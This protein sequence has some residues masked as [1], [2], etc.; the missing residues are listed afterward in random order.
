VNRRGLLAALLAFTTVSCDNSATDPG[1]QGPE[2]STGSG[3]SVVEYDQQTSQT[4]TL[5]SLRTS[6]TSDRLA[7]SL[8]LSTLGAP[9]L[10]FAASTSSYTTYDQR[11]DFAAVAGAIAHNYGFE[12]FAGEFFSFPPNPWT[13]NGVTYRTTNNLIVGP[14]T[15]F[16]P[17][18]RIFCYN[19]WTPVGG[20]LSPAAAYTVFGA[21]LSVISSSSLNSY[22]IDVVITT[23]LGIYRFDDLNVPKTNTKL[24]QFFGFVAKG[25]GEYIT[26]FELSSTGF[27]IGP[28]LDNVTVGHLTPVTP[29]TGNA[30][31]TADAGGPYAAAEGSRI[32]VTGS[33]TDPDPDSALTYGWDFDGDDVTDAT[34]AVAQHTYSQDGEYKARLI[35]SDGTLADTAEATINIAN[36]LPVVNAGPDQSGIPVGTS[37][38]ITPSFTDP[39]TDAPWHYSIEWSDGAEA[40]GTLATGDVTDDDPD[41]GENGD[42]ALPNVTFTAP[43]AG[44]FTITVKVRD[45]DGESSDVM[46]VAA[47]KKTAQVTLGGL[48]QSYDGSPRSA[49]ATTDPTGLKVDLTYDGKS[50][51]PTNVGSYT[52]V[53]TID[54]PGYEGSATGTLEITK[55]SQTISFR[56]LGDKTYGDQPFAVSATASSGLAV[57]VSPSGDCSISG[58]TVTIGR[59]GSCTIT[60]SQEGNGNYNPAESVQ[61]TF[62]IAK[63][64]PLITWATPAAI[65]YGTALSGTQL[66]A[67]ANVAGTFAYDPDAGAVLGAG[68]HT[69]TATFTPADANNYNGAQKTVTLTVN[70][71]TPVITWSHPADIVYGTVLGS[72][73][74]N[75]SA[76]V[77]GGLTYTP[78]AGAKLGVGD[79]QTLRADFLPTDASRYNTVSATVSINVKS[80]TVT[81]F[82]QPITMRTPGGDIVY[83]TVKAGT[84][85][86]LKFNVFQAFRSTDRRFEL[87]T[88]SA[89]GATFVAQKLSTCEAAATEDPIDEL[90]STG[91]TGLQYDLTGAQFV[92]NWQT[93]QVA[94][95]YRVTLTTADKSV[96]EAY[97]KLR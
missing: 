70:K 50:S 38:E 10:S 46:E 20:T 88:A 22:P 81:G 23:N 89:I 76:D 21:E 15:G 55:A 68:P 12:D 56:P 69:L 33:G 40:N 92:Q 67:Q 5:S 43:F 51:A 9:S 4:S 87:T 94:G 95:C 48:E 35:V 61:Q 63:A 6:T 52:V 31:P 47:D 86:P 36:A 77:P 16:E 65:T 1:R 7:P 30:A 66:D 18:S 11:A 71:A 85:V 54:Q 80:W 90:E 75:A 57:A 24:Q 45:E 3:L 19:E 60:A 74:L 97:F 44:T 53:A 42:G 84:T 96:I 2:L 83:N 62:A 37:V 49:S 58:T 91:G 25:T 78:A 29:G 32:T 41:D 72:G 28:C 13:A 8:S 93:P 82:Y 64:T 79:G 39:G 26:G 27:G 73:Q 17:P 14:R 59:A 34:T